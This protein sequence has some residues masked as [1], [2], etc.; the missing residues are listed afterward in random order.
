MKIIMLFMGCLI[1]LPVYAKPAVIA[2]FGGRSSGIPD[3][4]A[5]L[6]S[7]PVAKKPLGPV[8]NPFPIESNLQ[9]GKQHSFTH[10]KPVDEPFFIIGGDA[11]SLRWV[12]ENYHYFLEIQAK[13]LITNLNSQ[14]EFDNI[15]M[16]FPDVRLIAVNVDDMT[17]LFG[18]QHYPVFINKM[19]V[20]Q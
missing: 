6:K 12:S 4:S 16:L 18:I 13:G 17:T 3:V 1:G 19:S 14:E 2:D 10:N 8:F 11:Q 5:I 20:E 15:Q 7:S 9:L